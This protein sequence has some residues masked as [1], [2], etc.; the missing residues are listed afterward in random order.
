MQIR[1]LIEDFN[2]EFGFI[3]PLE[4]VVYGHYQTMITK[5]CFL[6]KEFGYEGKNCGACRNRKLALLDRMNYVFPITTD[7]D[8]NVTIYNSKALHLIEYISN[9]Y[10]MGITSIRLDFS[11]ETPDEVYE[12]TKAYL[13]KIRYN[14]Y[15]LNLS[16]VTF[17]YFLD[18]DKN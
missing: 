18:I 9:I 10:D 13:D 3:P 1:G 12:I 15:D 6:A 2:D 17:G 16:D 8:C 14:D 7:Y 11:V 4:M 5:H